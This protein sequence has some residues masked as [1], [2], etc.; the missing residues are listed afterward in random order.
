MSIKIKATKNYGL[1]KCSP[2]NRPVNLDKHCQLRDSMQRHGFYETCPIICRWEGEQLVVLDGQHRLAFAT[3]LGLTVFYVE[4][5]HDFSIAELNTT[6]KQWE[7]ADFAVMFSTTGKE[8][9][10]EVMEFAS[11]YKIPLGKA[12]CLFAGTMNFGNVAAAFRKGEF[13]IKDRPWAVAVAELY[14]ALT[15]IKP[16]FSGPRVVE[17]CMAVC[18]V[19]SFDRER[20]VANASRYTNLLDTKTTREEYLQ[21]F[22]DIY[23]YG[24]H[25]KLKLR[26]EAIAVLKARSATAKKESAEQAP[27][28][29]I[30]GEVA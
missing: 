27:P 5:E 9:Y 21:V 30:V 22:D 3:M 13:E 12:F 10:R 14:K 23:N 24:R 15:Q 20:M 29:R 11:T 16:R 2:H 19:P 7:T 4:T 6:A 26:D 8:Q 17:A 28:L 18:R 1:F 25:N